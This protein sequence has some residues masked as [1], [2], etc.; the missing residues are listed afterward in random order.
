VLTTDV[1][2][3]YEFLIDVKSDLDLTSRIESE[4]RYVQVRLTDDFALE[5]LNKK[6]Y[7]AAY[8]ACTA[9]LVNETWN[10]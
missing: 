2:T 10:L 6:S 5:S 7:I 8:D 9:V 1:E 3:F 4:G